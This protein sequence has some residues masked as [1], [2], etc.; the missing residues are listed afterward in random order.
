M[1]GGEHCTIKT[2][3]ILGMESRREMW[4]F[5]YISMP[6]EKLYYELMKSLVLI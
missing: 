6:C 4:G 5:N 3:Y 1:P 2:G